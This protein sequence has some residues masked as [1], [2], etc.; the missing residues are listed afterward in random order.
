MT[1]KKKISKNALVRANIMSVWYQSF[2]FNYETMQ[3]CGWVLAVEP[4][5][6]EI[7]GDQPELLSEKL[8][9]HFRFYNTNPYF[10]PL[11]T[12]MCLSLEEAG[13]AE[14]TDIAIALRTALMGPFAGLGDSLI[15][16]TGRSV[17]GSIAAYAAL[18]G[19]LSGYLFNLIVMAVVCFIRWKSFYIGYEQGSRFITDNT[20][21]FRNL[22]NS[23]SIIGLAVVGAM[24]PSMVSIQTVVT[25]TNGDVTA[26]LQG[27]FDSLLP[28]LLP[29]AATAAIY[30]GLKSPKMST[31]KMLWLII[32]LSIILHVIGIL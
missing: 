18:N 14:S 13:T 30:Y 3:S 20:E 16:I 1:N 26:T 15:F 25:Y 10:N 22:T 29:V 19:S 6:E 8:D 27:F 5:L 4:S 23:A 11:V 24:I 21:T 12:G 17:F 32:V 2:A 28:A 31:V 7:Y 9:K